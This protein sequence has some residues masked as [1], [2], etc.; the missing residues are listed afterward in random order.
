MYIIG[1]ILILNLGELLQGSKVVVLDKQKAC[2]RSE[3]RFLVFI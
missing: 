1:M 2:L 3:K